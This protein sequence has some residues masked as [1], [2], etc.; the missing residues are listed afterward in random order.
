MTLSKVLTAGPTGRRQWELSY[1]SEFASKFYPGDRFQTYVHLGRDP[2]LGREEELQG[3]EANLLRVGMRWADLIII[4]EKE[5][6]VVEGKLRPGEYMTGLAQLELYIRLVPHTQ[7]FLAYPQKDV[8]GIL[9]IPLE[10]PV[11][12]AMGREKGFR[13]IIW[14]P[15]WFQ[16]FLAS[17]TPRARRPSRSV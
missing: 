3:D 8:H 13:V 11:V 6:L 14:K 10:D 7:D 9:L 4:R 12:A 1:V 2:A 16:D 5:L 15:D 17:L